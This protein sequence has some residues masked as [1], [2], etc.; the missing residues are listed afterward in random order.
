[1]DKL[2]REALPCSSEQ[3]GIVLQT[4][5]KAKVVLCGKP[6][7][8][9]FRAWIRRNTH[10]QTFKKHFSAELLTENFEKLLQSALKYLELSIFIRKKKNQTNLLLN[11]KPLAKLNF[12]GL[13]L[14]QREM[15]HA[16][17]PAQ[18]THF[19]PLE[20]LPPTKRE[21]LSSNRDL[22]HSWELREFE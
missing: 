3:V 5:S 13:D 21:G 8:F 10:P 2:R 16:G 6:T 1:M 7:M 11:I 14:M 4:H 18:G 15:D 17:D 19:N 12:C 9:Y 20:R 22:A